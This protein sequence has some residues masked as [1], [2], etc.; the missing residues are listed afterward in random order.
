MPVILATQEA[1]I[2]RTV[3][4]SQPGQIVLKILSQKYP[5][6]KRAGRMAQVLEHLSNQ[7]EVLSSNPSTIKKKKK[8]V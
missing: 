5:M 1:E 6:Q 4:Q 2:R 8:V 7:H 3:V